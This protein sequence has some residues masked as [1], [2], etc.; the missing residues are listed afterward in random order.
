V[1]DASTV[2]FRRFDRADA[3]KR[4]DIV[5]LIHR[6][7]YSADNASRDAFASDSAFMQRFDAYTSRLEFDL[8]IAYHRS[9]PIGQT[10][11]W[12]LTADTVWWDDLATEPEPGFT[13]EDGHRTFALSELMVRQGWTGRGVAHA[14]HDELLQR[15]REHRATLLVRPENTLAYR[16]YTRWGWRS[17][18]QLRPNWPD[19][20][21]M[22]VLIMPLP[23]RK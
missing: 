6:A 18:G 21:L 15:R 14:L 22:D 1:S 10:W 7:A 20:P 2:Q 23:L 19:A 11:G 16:A 17:V 4:R 9:E 3:R 5:A 8:V 13:V 12:A